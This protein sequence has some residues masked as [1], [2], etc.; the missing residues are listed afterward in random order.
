MDYGSGYHKSI[1][2]SAS[3]AIWPQANNLVHIAYS[4][5]YFIMY[6]NTFGKGFL[7][8]THTGSGRISQTKNTS[9]KKN[10][11]P[12]ESSFKA[13]CLSFKNQIYF[14]FLICLDTL[15]IRL[16]VL[17]SNNKSTNLQSHQIHQYCHAIQ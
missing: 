9:I 11:G 6:V 3:A 16:L 2:S 12:A 8:W 10:D 4:Q 13:T 1:S 15:L 14:N 7:L 5:G 17:D